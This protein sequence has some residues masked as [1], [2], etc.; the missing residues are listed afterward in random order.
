MGHEPKTIGIFDDHPALALGIR[1]ELEATGHFT[2]AVMATNVHD[3]LQK[4]ETV[5]L[6]LAVMDIVAADVSGLELFQKVHASHPEIAMVA[7][8]SLSSPMLVDNL[9]RTGAAGYVNKRQPVSELVDALL[10]VSNGG[11]HVPAQ[12]GFLVAKA[13]AAKKPLTLSPREID[14]L[15]R[16]VSGRLSKEIADEFGI[17]QNTVENHRSNLFRKFNVANVAELIVQAGQMGYG[18][19]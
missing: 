12:Y 18:L 11:V 15:K 19:A 14:I 9:L 6:D 16:V 13:F 7:Y 1:A 2:V 8:T 17:S 10:H 5:E 4:L 3:F